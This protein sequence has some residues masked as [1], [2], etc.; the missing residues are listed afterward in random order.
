MA[1]T[2]FLP[3][4]LVA[5]RVSLVVTICGHVRFLFT[6]DVSQMRLRA[7]FTETDFS[8]R[9]LSSIHPNFGLC[10]SRLSIVYV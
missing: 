3:R 4:G 8:F 1:A 6:A 5:Q 2:V 7:S 10:F 9:R